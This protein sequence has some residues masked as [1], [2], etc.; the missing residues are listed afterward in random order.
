[1][2]WRH[3]RPRMAELRLVV[4]AVVRLGNLS[5]VFRGHL[6]PK[7]GLRPGQGLAEPADHLAQGSCSSTPAVR[8]CRHPEGRQRGRDRAPGIPGISGCRRGRVRVVSHWF[9]GPVPCVAPP[10]RAGVMIIANTISRLVTASRS[11][12]R[13]ARRQG[14]RMATKGPPVTK[15]LLLKANPR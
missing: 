1:M 15:R 2:L 3:T 8:G 6:K 10:L 9:W 5:G 14:A 7:P 13:A 12:R 11:H 4:T